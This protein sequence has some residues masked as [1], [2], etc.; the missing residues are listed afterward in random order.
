MIQHSR[1][2][3]LGQWSA[4]QWTRVRRLRGVH[5]IRA[6]TGRATSAVGQWPGREVHAEPNKAHP[7]CERGGV[8]LAAGGAKVF[9]SVPSDTPSEHGS[10]A[11]ARLVQRETVQDEAAE[12]GHID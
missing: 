3:S 8:E 10:I 9:E 1:R 2:S 4:V 6:P 12:P 5:G 11:S 7:S